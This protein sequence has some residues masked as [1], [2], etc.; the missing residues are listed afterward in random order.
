MSA[1]SLGTLAMIYAADELPSPVKQCCV[2]EI[3][4]TL[5]YT[6]TERSIVEI[7]GMVVSIL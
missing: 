1:K 5:S 4:I 7:S 2:K 3:G 6:N